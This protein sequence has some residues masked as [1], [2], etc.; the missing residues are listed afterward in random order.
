VVGVTGSNGKTTMKEMTAAIL[1]AQYGQRADGWSHVLATIGNLNNE[2]G[3]P[4]TLS[5]LRDWHRAAVIEMGAS[6]QGDIRLLTDIARPT[7][8]I[9]T[10]AGPAHLEGFGGTVAHVARGKGELFAGLG[11][12]ATAVVNIDDAYGEYWRGVNHA[13]RIVTYGTRPGADCHAI[14]IRTEPQADGS[15][16][17]AFRLVTPAGTLAVALPMAG[18]HNAGNAAGAAAAALAAG[19]S[20]AAVAAGLGGMANVAGRLK[21]TAG[22]RGSRIFDDSYNANPGSVAAAIEFLATLPGERWLALGQMAELGA[23]GARLHREVGELARARGI[24]RLFAIGDLTRHAAEGFGARAT[25][26]AD[27]DALVAAVEPGLGPGITLLVK[28]SRSAGME[29]LIEGL[30]GDAAVAGHHA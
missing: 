1:T 6:K 11:A 28:G 18:R 25:W 15:P 10:N 23:D 17:L 8:G 20:L 22:P 26:F 3:V 4:L 29:Q 30:V 27:F 12:D 9:I 24:E 7:V 21:A 13:G 16:G 19:A 14:D 2:I 5:W